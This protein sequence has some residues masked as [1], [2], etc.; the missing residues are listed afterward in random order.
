MALLMD[1]KNSKNHPSEVEIVGGVIEVHLQNAPLLTRANA[2]LA[3]AK[4]NKHD[5]HQIILASEQKLP[6]F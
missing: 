4:R 2:G 6:L 5:N 3:S 1:D